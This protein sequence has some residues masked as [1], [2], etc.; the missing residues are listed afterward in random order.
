MGSFFSPPP[1]STPTYPRATPTTCRAGSCRSSESATRRKQTLRIFVSAGRCSTK[2]ASPWTWRSG[3]CPTSARRP[4]RCDPWTRRGDMTAMK[5]AATADL[6]AR[7]GDTRRLRT[8]AEGAARDADVLVIGGDLTD[9]GRV[10]QAE[11]FLE[12]LDA[13]P[14]PIVATLGNH[15]HES[16]NADVLSHLFAGSGIHLLDRSSVVIDGVG[17]SGVKGFCGG[18]DRDVAN[19]FGE[20]LFKA[21]V[22]EGILDAEALKRELRGL[23]M[24]RRVAVL[25]YSPIRATVEGE[26]PEIFPYLGTSRLARALDEGD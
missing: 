11:V 24:E 15:D 26:P 18:F 14:I 22:T 17:F 25:H 16:G 7:V 1:P 4:G 5:I 12:A 20:D 13:C 8:L 9:L 10:E 23:E 21:W 6:H 19:P 2:P 3:A